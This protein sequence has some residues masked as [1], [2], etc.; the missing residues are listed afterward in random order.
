MPEAAR[1]PDFLSHEDVDNRPEAAPARKASP[2]EWLPAAALDGPV[3]RADAASGVTH[4]VVTGLP[5]EQDS[6]QPRPSAPTPAMVS[7][8]FACL[9]LPRLPQ[10]HLIGEMADRLPGYL[11]QSCLAFGWRLGHIAIRPDY[12]L[13]LVETPP[14]TAAGDLIATLRQ[15]L[16]KFLF[17]DFP[18]LAT[19]NPS[20]DFWAPG[21]L[22]MSSH[23][24]PPAQIVKE[25]IANTRKFQ[26]L[27]GNDV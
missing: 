2:N 23:Q 17:R 4:V 5:E 13:W 19:D 21:Y 11:R 22:I 25:F 20:G 8:S 12:L 7:L 27:R 16:S 1:Q 15:E 10:H 9:L 18:Y 3:L 26:G 24:P 14:T 6:A